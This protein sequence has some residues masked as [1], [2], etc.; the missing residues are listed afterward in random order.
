MLVCPF[1]FVFLL[2]WG[3]SEVGFPV[4]G[5]VDLTL[6]GSQLLKKMGYIIHIYIYMSYQPIVP[7]LTHFLN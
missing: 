2:Q 7:N 6:N 4:Q 1:S 5:Q 3:G